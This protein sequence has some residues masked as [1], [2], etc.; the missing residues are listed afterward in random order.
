VLDEIVPATFE[1]APS[2]WRAL[3]PRR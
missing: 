3:L 1:N 2:L